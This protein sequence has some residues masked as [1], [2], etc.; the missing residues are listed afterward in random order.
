MKT[1][2]EVVFKDGEKRI[3]DA[4]SFRIKAEGFFSFEYDEDD[5]S[6][7]VAYVSMYEVKY[8]KF[9]KVEE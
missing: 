8:L 1:N 9:V 5:Y 4:N 3:F 6:K 7:L 2:I